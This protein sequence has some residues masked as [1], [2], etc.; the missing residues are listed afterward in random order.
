[1]ITYPKRR[2]DESYNMHMRKALTKELSNVPIEMPD[3][4][5]GSLSERT[6]VLRAMRKI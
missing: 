1:M 3:S 4:W 6:I 2:R 5:P